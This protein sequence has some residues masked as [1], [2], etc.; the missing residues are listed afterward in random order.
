VSIERFTSILFISKSRILTKLRTQVITALSI[1]GFN[2]TIY[3]S[4]LISYGTFTF[5]NWLSTNENVSQ[6]LK[7]SY[8]LKSHNSSDFVFCD[9]IS[10]QT[11]KILS[12]LD[13][14]NAAIIPF[15]IMIFC[16]IQIIISIF[17]SRNR[18]AQTQ[19]NRRDLKRLK[20]DI[21]FSFTTLSLNFIFIFFTLPICVYLGVISDPDY[22]K[23][24]LYL[25][26]DDLYYIGYSVGVII[27]SISNKMFREELILLIEETYSTIPR[28]NSR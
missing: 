1:M 14:F 9:I 5:S 7:N 19:Q 10:I 11:N 6:T 22:T 8:A 25:I 17:R 4:F 3:S 23:T 15:I 26:L 27:Y 20:R 12:V 16:S 21:S 24:I 2:I 13:A 28:I 18:L